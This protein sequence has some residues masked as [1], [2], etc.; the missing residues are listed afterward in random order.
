MY[1]WFDGYVRAKPGVTVEYKPEWQWLR[2]FVGGKSFAHAALSGEG[3]EA[4][5]L[6]LRCSELDIDALR[7]R[8]K[9]A[10]PGYYTNKKA[11]LTLWFDLAAVPGRDRLAEAPEGDFPS[12]EQVK[13]LA[14]KAYGLIFSKLT[15]KQREEIAS[16]VSPQ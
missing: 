11:F 6:T 13:A 1:E 8:Y 2:Y 9:A 4:H 16:G 5:A 3:G 12:D 15:K 10:A 14:D 7:Q